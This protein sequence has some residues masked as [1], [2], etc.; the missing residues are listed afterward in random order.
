MGGEKRKNTEEFN[1][2]ISHSSTR[3][4]LNKHL[5]H[6]EVKLIPFSEAFQQLSHH[7]LGLSR[8]VLIASVVLVIIIA[9]VLA[10]PPVKHQQ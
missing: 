4:N 10:E 1:Q 7:C 5:R 2:S 3:V 6:T 9:A 8:Y